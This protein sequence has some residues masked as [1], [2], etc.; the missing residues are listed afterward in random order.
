[1]QAHLHTYVKKVQTCPSSIVR[2]SFLFLLPFFVLVFYSA[3]TQFSSSL[4]GG[5]SC[6]SMFPICFHMKPAW[7]HC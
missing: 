6:I 1:V 2:E 7:W 5:I 3:T 4:L